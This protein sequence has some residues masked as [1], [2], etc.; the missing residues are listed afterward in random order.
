[1]KS[2][3]II[4]VC[5][6]CMLFAACDSLF[7]QETNE[8][9]IASTKDLEQ[10]KAQQAKKA[11]EAD[12]LL[13][14]AQ[15]K[16]DSLAAL[17]REDSIKHQN[18]LD[19]PT[20]LITITT[21]FGTMH[22]ILYDETKKHKNNFIKLANEG[23]YNGTTFHRIVKGFMIQGGDPNSKDDIPTNDG[24]GGPGYTIPAEIL[25]KYKHTKGAIAAAR[26]GDQQNPQRA[27][28]GSQF[29][30][31]HDRN[32]AKNLDGQYTVFG[33]LVD[34]YETLDEIASQPA[35]DQMAVEKIPMEIA[36]KEMAR[37]EIEEQYNFTF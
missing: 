27:S 36:T 3:N 12:S 29:Y 5:F 26:L 17:N 30:I 19:E 34:G 37:R 4:I 9:G 35:K 11:A 7:Q 33:H 2:N 1:M 28:S 14:L 10:A 21:D 31:V 23:F 16:A 20:T 8:E 32:G 13:A 6:C 25:P 22:A 18:W 15:A 24:Q